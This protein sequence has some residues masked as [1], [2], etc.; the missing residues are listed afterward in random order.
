M[1]GD[2]TIDS[3]LQ[4]RYHGPH[5]RTLLPGGLSNCQGR[6][7]LFFHHLSL[8]VCLFKRS[9]KSAN[10]QDRKLIRSENFA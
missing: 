6:S 9:E 8:P 4:R 10:G 5:E 3:Q 7:F 2:R 1:P